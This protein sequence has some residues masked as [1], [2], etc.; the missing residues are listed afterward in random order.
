MAD[1]F[2]ITYAPKARCCVPAGV[3]EAQ[4]LEVKRGAFFGQ[5]KLY[6]KFRIIQGKYESSEIWMPVNLY[7][8]VAR[9]SKYFEL[10]VV[11]N[12]GVKPKANDRMSPK[13]FLNKIFKIKIETVFT[14]RKQQKLS[15][16]ERYS[17]VREIVEL[18][19]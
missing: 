12:K 7:H 3:Y 8:K 4:C 16:E 5:Q 19:A 1:D 14:N 15:D 18:C 17:V 13:I 6:F 11:A 9:A 2:L 10:W